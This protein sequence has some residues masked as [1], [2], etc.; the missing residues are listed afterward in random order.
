MIP[1][2]KVSQSCSSTHTTPTERNVTKWL[3]RIRHHRSK[4]F[5]RR[6]EFSR[7]QRQ[8]YRRRGT[9]SWPWRHETL[10]YLA[11]FWP[12]VS[13]DIRQMVKACNLCNPPPSRATKASCIP[14][15]PHVHNKSLELTYLI[16]TKRKYLMIV[17]YFS[18]FS[19]IKV[20]TGMVVKTIIITSSKV[21]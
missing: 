4:R 2:R 16:T 17:D 11:V 20:L 10:I 3:H 9:L 18:R 12:D 14:T 21:S 6:G 1:R 19:V 13:N 15:F 5:D 7:M 8:G